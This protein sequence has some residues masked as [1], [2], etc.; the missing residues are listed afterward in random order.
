MRQRTLGLDPLLG[1]GGEGI[2]QLPIRHE[3]GDTVS[4]GDIE[5]RL[6]ITVSILWHAILKEEE[7]RR[8][9]VRLMGG[10]DVG[11][12]LHLGAACLRPLT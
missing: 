11:T 8:S 6:T 9:H 10:M 7:G 3:Y 12:P 5:S 1:Q 4:D 2:G